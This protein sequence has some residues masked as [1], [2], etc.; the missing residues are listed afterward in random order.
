[1]AWALYALSNT[2]RVE[3]SKIREEFNLPNKGNTTDWPDAA[4]ASSDE[5]PEPPA[6][7]Q[8]L[9]SS[10][11]DYDGS[12]EDCMRDDTLTSA[13]G[14]QSDQG[15]VTAAHACCADAGE[16]KKPRD[17]SARLHPQ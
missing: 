3:S 4:D 2:V 12:S 13:G 17:V 9:S 1:M 10:T 16:A 14:S 15:E 5:E 11:G 7:S 8:S 6:A